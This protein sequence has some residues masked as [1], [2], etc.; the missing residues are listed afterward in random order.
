MRT[1]KYAV[2]DI[3]ATTTRIAWDFKS[4]TLFHKIEI[5]TSQRYRE[6][7][8]T[9]VQ[10]VKKEGIKKIIVGVASPLDIRRERLLHSP[11]LPNYRKREPVRDFR[12]LGITVNLFNDLELAVLGEATYG[13]GQSFHDVAFI[14]M[15]T[16]TGGA[17][18]REK[19][20]VR[21][22]FNFEPGHQI[23][24]LYGPSILGKTIGSFEAFLSGSAA[25]FVTKRQSGQ[26]PD[27]YFQKRIRRLSQALTNV[28]VFWAP[29]VIVLGGGF[30][31]RFRKFLPYLRKE[32]RKMLIIFPNPKIV[33][34]NLKGDAGLIG[35]FCIA[36]QHK[37]HL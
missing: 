36:K 10:T 9:I 26:L 1:A 30:G 31:V 2:I 12:R 29:E 5:K 24:D 37:L 23:L 14:S 7:I 28:A 35:G 3:G 11:N 25:Q 4:T 34:G 22:R 27:R 17:L 33:M 21:G 32:L 16:G 8:R 13:A 15:A 6:E 18:A 19:N 20:L